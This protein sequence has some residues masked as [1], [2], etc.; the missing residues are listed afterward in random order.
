[1]KP[2]YPSSLRLSFE[3]KRL[4]Y[5]I[6]DKLSISQTAVMELIIREKAKQEGLMD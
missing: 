5:K 4:L 1:M 3:A 6:A 2:K